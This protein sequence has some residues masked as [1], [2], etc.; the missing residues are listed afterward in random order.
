M[1]EATGRKAFAGMFIV[2]Y[3]GAMWLITGGKVDDVA[4][5]AGPIIF[6]AAAI[7]FSMLY[8]SVYHSHLNPEELGYPEKLSKP[9]LHIDV[10]K[11]TAHA[12]M[13]EKQSEV[14][15]TH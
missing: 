13:S 12:A 6:S 9:P 7:V 8:L 1:C 14:H 3:I 10:A 15:S 2:A 11:F 5:A 4:V